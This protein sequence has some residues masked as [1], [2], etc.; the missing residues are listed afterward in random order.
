MV[1]A[2][3]KKKVELAKII[4]RVDTLFYTEKKN[5]IIT[6]RTALAICFLKK[7]M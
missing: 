7:D 4:P 2:K 5:I 3:C 1:L 6:S